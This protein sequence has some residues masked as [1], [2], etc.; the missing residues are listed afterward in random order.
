MRGFMDTLK[1]YLLVAYWRRTF[2]SP[3]TATAFLSAIGFFWLITEISAFIV[4]SWKGQ[5]QNA[6]PY[7]LGFSALYT[8]YRQ[9]PV[10]SKCERLDGT[11]IRIEIRIADIF[12]IKAACVISTNT[13]F[14]SVVNDRIISHQSLQG[15]FTVLFYDKSEHLDRDLDHALLHEQATGKR[16]SKVGGK[17]KLYPIGTV[18]KVTPKGR[19]AYLLA[20]SELNEHGVAES[21]FEAVKTAL[22]ALWNFVSS[23][24]GYDAI[25]IPVIGTGHGRIN[26]P[27]DVVIKEIIRSFVAACS[28]RK[29][30]SKLTVV[31]SPRDYHDNELDIYELGDFLKYACRYSEIE[32]AKRGSGTAIS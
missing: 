11:D 28:E 32:P 25:A 9:R 8:I 26:T 4:E 18:A 14:D 3:D 13:S 2:L 7:F 10:I 17:S 22:A 1:G 20:I 29:F 6:W 31:I 5:L 12:S 27:R 23:K 15:M 21:N 16:Q 30:S 19:T 24:G